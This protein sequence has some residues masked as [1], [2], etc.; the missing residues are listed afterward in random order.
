MLAFLFWAIG[1]CGAVAM[2]AAIYFCFFDGLPGLRLPTFLRSV[3]RI[4]YIL[5]NF[6][7]DSL[8]AWI[9]AWIRER[10][11]PSRSLAS[12]VVRSFMLLVLHRIKIYVNLY[13]FLFA[14]P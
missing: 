5:P 12:D 14:K 3:S 13:S 11:T 1:I 6:R 9:N 7:A 2:V 10:L 8:P 4:R